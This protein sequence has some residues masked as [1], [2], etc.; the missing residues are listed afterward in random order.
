MPPPLDRAKRPATTPQAPAPVRER[1]IQRRPSTPVPRSN[2]AVVAAARAGGRGPGGDPAARELQDKVGNAAVADGLRRGPA[3]DPKF[4]VLKRDV[5]QKKRTVATSHPPPR[6]EAVSAQDAAVPPKDDAVAQGKAANAEKMNEAEPKGFDKAAFIEAVAKA[7]ADRAPKN[8]KEAEKFPDSEKPAEINTEVRGRVGEGKAESAE[9]IA[10]TTAAPPDTSAAVPKQVVPMAADRPPGRPGTPDP[11]QAAPDTLPLAATDMSAGPAAV[12]RQMADAQVTETQL[13]KS[14]EPTFANALSSKKA[15]EQHSDTAPEQLRRHEAAQLRRT[16]A[17]ARQLGAASMGAMA[18]ARVRTGQLVGTGKTGA[19]TRDEEKRAEVTALLQKV[20]DKMKA[21]VEGILSGLDRLVD[22]QFT[23]EEKAARDAFTAEHKRKLADYKDRRYSGINRLKW[24]KDWLVGLPDEVNAFLEEARANYVR[25]MR[26]VVSNIADTIARELARAKRRIADGRAELRAAVEKLP[27]DLRAIG[28]EAV[29]EFAD[30]FDELTRSVDDKGTELVDALATKYTDAVRA[31]DQEIAEQ[32]EENKGAV[33]KAKD[34]IKGVIDAIMEMKRLLLGVLRKAAT[35][36]GAILGDPIGFLGNLVTGVGGG[37]K[38]FL[39][40][41][42][43]HLRQGV[44]A[45]LLGTAGGVG[46]QLPATF[47]VVGILVMIAGLLGLSWP[48]IRSRLT[49]RVPEQAVAAAETA[50]PLV[51]ETRKRGVAGMWSELKARVGDLKETLVKDLVSYLLPTIIIAGITWIVSLL[52]PASAFLRACKL[53][54]DIIRFIVTQGRRLI[55]F[56][57]AVLDAVIA[58][59][60]G[61]TGGVPALVERALARSIPVLIGALAAILGIGGIAGKVRQIFQKLAA[62]VN[63]AVDWVIDKIVD[64]VKK[65]W[66]KLKAALDTRRPKGRREPGG[67]RRPVAGRRPDRKRPDDKQPDDK[68][69]DEKRP[70]ADTARREEKDRA[71]RL[72]K[73]MAAAR[74]VMARYARKPVGPEEV[75]GRL[76]AVRRKF[77]ARR[78]DLVDTGRV[79]AVDAE[80]NPKK[81]EKTDALVAG[82]KRGD[83]IFALALGKQ[84]GQAHTGSAVAVRSLDLNRSPAARI[85]VDGLALA[86]A[87]AAAIPELVVRKPRQASGSDAHSTTYGNASRDALLAINAVAVTVARYY[88]HRADADLLARH[89][90][91]SAAQARLAVNHWID[92]VIDRESV[93]FVQDKGRELALGQRLLEQIRAD[94]DAVFA[95]LAGRVVNQSGAADDHD[96]NRLDAALRDAGALVATGMPVDE[97]RARLPAVQRRHGLTA[98]SLVVERLA[99][100]HYVI[101]FVATIN[102]SKTSRAENSPLS[103]KKAQADYG[104]LVKNSLKFQRYADQHN[105]IIEVRPTNPDSIRHLTRGAW[106]KPVDIKAKTINYAD[107]FLSVEPEKKGLVGFFLN[108]V[109]LPKRRNLGKK[110]I[111]AGRNRYR[112]RVAEHHEYVGKMRKLARNPEGPGRF[113]VIGYVVHGYDEHKVRH[114]IAG[115]HDLYDI[116]RPDGTEIPLDEYN[117]IIQ[118]MASRRFGVM[119]GAVVHWDPDDPHEREMRD[120]LVRQHQRGGGEGLVR[121]TPGQPMRF[122]AAETPLWTDQRAWVPPAGRADQ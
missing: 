61:G 10:T 50:V 2:A 86:R 46:L 93:P 7:V 43:L 74:R 120:R 117:L 96:L 53:I 111:E 37:L 80:V 91:V 81:N 69:P 82:P 48:N 36:I 19:K 26:G 28:R 95:R 119:H 106:Y 87:K 38:L 23:R 15:A 70:D 27:E 9:Q 110:D 114:P 116:R 60:R 25:R 16:T 92:A 45:W 71:D 102:P 35:A 11:K 56:V 13:K 107:T 58:I 112:M 31:V 1:V 51:V 108:A 29:S 118:D 105:L 6:E 32:K 24:F 49:R 63:R 4:A 8:L 59:A 103:R 14:N 41:A 89:L 122:V 88:E 62:P 47:D 12:D 73:V 97:I 66:A 21:D 67:T 20:F 72:D 3:G 113:E 68:Q 57:N 78:V 5:A 34:A 18:G 104:V 44:L 77:R 109:P 65:L 79:W 84:L 90:A 85:L 101:H 83:H 40:N 115:D 100:D 99:G 94:L 33:D 54:V 30:K 76:A 39:R 98:L 75:T 55:E 64:L 42:G 17:Q 22:E 52:N 121:F